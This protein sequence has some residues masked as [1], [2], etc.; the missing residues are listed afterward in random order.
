MTDRNEWLLWRKK[1]IGSSDAPVIMGVSKFSTPLKLYETKIAETVEED[2]SNSY[3]KDMGNKF[4]TKIRSLFELQQGRS[5]SPAL[6]E[7]HIEGCAMPFLASLD[8][9]SEDFEQIIE[10]KLLGYEDWANAH[11][12]DD[13]IGFPPPQYVPQM[14][15][16]LFVEERAKVCFF[17][18]Y[19]YE[20][21]V[22]TVDLSK[23]VVI[24]VYPDKEY[25][26]RLFQE[27]IKFMDAVAKR[28]PPVPSDKDYKAIKGKFSKSMTQWKKLKAKADALAEKLEAKRNE[29]IALAEE[30]KHP[31]L[32]ASGVKLRQTARIGNVNYKNIPELKGVDLEQYRGKGSVSWTFEVEKENAN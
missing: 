8:G 20:K 30:Q 21:G 24:P 31:R 2:T 5:F 17:V 22:H 26:G 12:D 27:T 14:Q 18:G 16:Q 11:T 1:G 32:T 29:I 3:I 25:Q 9:R 19:L 7:R 28:K 4:E 15:H 10:I 23:L 6:V 13:H